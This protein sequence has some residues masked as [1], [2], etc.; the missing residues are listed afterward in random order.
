MKKFKKITIRNKLVNQNRYLCLKTTS[1]EF[2]NVFLWLICERMTTSFMNSSN[3]SSS[4]TF[5]FLTA[6]ILPS[7]NIPLYTV[8][9]PPCPSTLSMLKFSVAFSNSFELNIFVCSTL[10][11]VEINCCCNN[12][13]PFRSKN[14]FLRLILL[15][16]LNN[17]YR[18]YNPP[19]DINVT[20]P[21]TIPTKPTNEEQKSLWE[22]G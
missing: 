20:K 22:E 11:W 13:P 7:T 10:P 12:K 1:Q 9:W 3:L 8:P 16:L 19:I 2:D 17:L 6:T 18:Q 5:D 14:F 21:I 4:T 15:C